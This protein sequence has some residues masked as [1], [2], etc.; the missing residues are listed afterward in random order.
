MNEFEQVHALRRRL[1]KA[2]YDEAG[3]VPNHPVM[4]WKIAERMEGLDTSDPDYVDSLASAAQVLGARGLLNRVSSDWGMF[5]LTAD[6]IDE[7]E[8][9]QA[10]QQ[11]SSVTNVNISGG[12]FQG[13]VV[14]AN[15]TAELVNNFDLRSVEIEQQIEERGGADKEELREALEEVRRI[16]ASE[17]N[18]ERGML[19]RF[20]DVME[21]HSWFTGAIAQAFAGFVTQAITG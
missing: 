3:G 18:I 2:A 19:A 4:L 5:S 10:A 20:S 9:T 17:N 6:G 16:I 11:P 13:S 8:G 21:R 1:L 12:T 7:V 15:N 14:G